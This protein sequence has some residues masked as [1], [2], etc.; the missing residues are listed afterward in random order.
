MFPED[1]L[2]I[3]SGWWRQVLNIGQTVVIAH[4]V[5]CRLTFPRYVADTNVYT[6]RTV[7]K[8]LQCALRRAG[9]DELAVQLRISGA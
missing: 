1:L 4:D 9:F 7:R 3:P 2:F 6:N 5:C 8:R